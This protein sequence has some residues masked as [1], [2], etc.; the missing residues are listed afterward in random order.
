[1]NNYHENRV[2]DAF[3]EAI[4]KTVGKGEEIKNKI[5]EIAQDI[6]KNEISVS[7]ISKEKIKSIARDA[8]EG[9]IQGTKE[10]KVKGEDLTRKAADG[11]IEAIRQ[12]SG[13]VKG[14]TR[15]Y[16]KQASF[17]MLDAVKEAG[18]RVIDSVNGALENIMELKQKSRVT[19]KCQ[20]SNAA[21]V[22]LVGSFNNWSIDATPMRKTLKGHWSVTITLPYGKYEYRYLIDGFWYTDPDTPRVPNKFGSENSVMVVGND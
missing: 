22:Y 5:Q 21:Q 18:D 4:I 19:F 17:G 11:I 3:R 14:K 7:G 8:M 13:S 1:M 12:T 10:A 2:K 16:L 15:E 20:A 6:L 9:V